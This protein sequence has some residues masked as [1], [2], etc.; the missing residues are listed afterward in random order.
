[1]A[2]PALGPLLHSLPLRQGVCPS[3][4]RA[5][6]PDCI[7]LHRLSGQNCVLQ[8]HCWLLCPCISHRCSAQV[9]CV[10][11]ALKA[12][13]RLWQWRGI[14]FAFSGCLL[15]V[16]QPVVS[17]QTAVGDCDDSRCCVFRMVGGV[18]AAG[19][20]SLCFCHT[21][22]TLTAVKSCAGLE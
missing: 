22:G 3:T 12:G 4:R 18:L 1:L 8:Q 7:L 9:K 20:A 2:R 6:W 10:F 14:S 15:D 13:S 19:C 16:S 11:H 17:P 21:R 5:W